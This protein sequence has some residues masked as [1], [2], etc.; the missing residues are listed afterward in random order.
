MYAEQG[1]AELVQHLNA[2]EE[3]V[4]VYYII[5]QVWLSA[6]RGKQDN[7]FLIRY[8]S[9]L[10]GVLLLATAYRLNR[11]LGLPP[12]GAV[13][14]VALLGLSP[15][16]TVHIREA[17]MYGLNVGAIALSTWLA[18]RFWRQPSSLRALA[19]ALACALALFTHYFNAPF[20]AALALWGLIAARGRPR[21]DW[22]LA[23]LAVAAVFGVW[24]LLA[25]RGLLQSPTA[26]GQSR[27]SAQP[28][29]G[30][31]L[32]QVAEVG[33]F[34]YRDLPPPLWAA[35]A[36]LGLAAL[37]LTATLILTGAKR[38]L[39]AGMIL[40]PGAAYAALSLLGFHLIPRYVMP[41]L[42]FATA[43]AGLL[44]SRRPALGA[45]LGLALAAVMLPAT[46]RTLRQP[47]EPLLTVPR[48]SYL[49]NTTRDMAR[50]LIQ[51]A[52]PADLFAQRTPDYANCYYLGYYFRSTLGCALIP[53]YPHQPVSELTG[54]IAQ[55]LTDHP[56]IWWVDFYNPVWDPERAADAAWGVGALDLG[57]ELM[58]GRELRLFTSAQTV[59]REQRQASAT[60]GGAARLTGVWL[61]PGATA[62]HLVLVWQAL[63]DHPQLQAKVFVHLA[64]EAGFSLSQ[65]DG[66]PVSWTRPLKTWTAG[67]QLLDIHTLPLPAGAAPQAGWVLQ[68]GMYDSATLVRLAGRGPAGDPLAEDAVRVPL[69]EWISP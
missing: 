19:A 3:H 39:V 38:W 1:F 21:R 28:G 52:N 43:G 60:F 9:V 58:G 31:A 10:G 63:R 11:A 37:W 20:I 64:D 18:L 42:L 68:I 23:M 40:I 48:D 59:R 57:H 33:L 56:V 29:L 17:R 32:M 49:T 6:A 47:Y 65:D 55:M 13:G 25:G 41:W 36:G 53:E 16:V 4:P 7:E 5:Q 69:S 30:S 14:A 61:R 27:A 67:E 34:G 35:L 50:T 8:T 22:F 15:Q 54:Q 24:L 66:V 26:L 12:L 62:L 44:A 51:V 46:W 45:G 2:D